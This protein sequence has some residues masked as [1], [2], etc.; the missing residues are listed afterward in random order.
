MGFKDYRVEVDEALRR[1]SIF[2]YDHPVLVK[3]N[4]PTLI[5]S[6]NHLGQ[7]IARKSGA[8]AIFFDLNNYRQEREGLIAELARAAA[9]KVLLTGEDVA[10]PTMNSYERRLVHVALAIHPDVTTESTGEKKDRHVIIKK[11]QS[12]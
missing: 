7:M 5:E 6:I 1:G 9:K 12:A 11:I 2:L 10:L 3:E 8:S 4:L